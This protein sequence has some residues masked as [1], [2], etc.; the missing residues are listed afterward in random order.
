MK[1]INK[2][3]R[4]DNDGSGSNNDNDVK[5]YGDNYGDSYSNHQEICDDKDDNDD[6]NS[7]NNDQIMNARIAVYIV[8]WLGMVISALMLL[9]RIYLRRLSSSSRD[10]S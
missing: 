3:D 1:I 2:D 7:D 4:N 8:L 10:I 6:D 9:S 5:D